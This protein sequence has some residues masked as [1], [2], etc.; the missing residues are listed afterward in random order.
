[1]SRTF[2]NLIVWEKSMK[3]CTRIYEVTGD[4]PDQERYGLIDQMRRSAVSIPS[5]IAE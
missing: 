4:F 3:L 2:K 5:N 1:M